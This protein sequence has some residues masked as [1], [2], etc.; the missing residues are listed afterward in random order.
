MRSDED[1]TRV[2]EKVVTPRRRK[3]L[4]FLVVL[5]LALWILVVLATL[6]RSEEF[7]PYWVLTIPGI[8]HALSAGFL[9]LP[10]DTPGWQIL[11]VSLSRLTGSPLGGLLFLPFG[12]IAAF[13]TRL[14]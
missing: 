9:A 13:P 3:F 14:L 4:V 10:T 6:I 12:G 2:A 8:D 11:M 1:D 5:A 7:D